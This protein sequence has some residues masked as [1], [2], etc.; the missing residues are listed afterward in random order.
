M[1]SESSPG[2]P[3]SEEL[4]PGPHRQPSSAVLKNAPFFCGAVLKRWIRQG[5]QSHSEPLQN[6]EVFKNIANLHVAE[7]Q[8]TSVFRGDLKQISGGVKEDI[9]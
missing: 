9:D 7:T 4:V 1:P 5:K 6:A 2:L 8:N 3:E